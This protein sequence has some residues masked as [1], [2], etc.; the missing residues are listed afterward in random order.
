MQ[1]ISFKKMAAGG[2]IT[3]DY[4]WMQTVFVSQPFS[5]A[6]QKLMTL[7]K[8]DDDVLPFCESE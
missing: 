6:R 5:A 2:P 7:R 1:K 3:A 8:A 4:S